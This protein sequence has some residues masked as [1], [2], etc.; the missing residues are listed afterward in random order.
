MI[1]AGMAAIDETFRGSL[2]AI[3]QGDFANQL[4]IPAQHVEH[5]TRLVTSSMRA[6][7]AN[8]FPLV[9]FAAAGLVLFVLMF[10]T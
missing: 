9:G 4:A 10:R 5:F 8:H 1:L 3:L 2:V 6:A 7:G